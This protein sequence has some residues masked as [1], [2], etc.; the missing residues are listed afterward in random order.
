[1]HVDGGRFSYVADHHAR[2]PTYILFIWAIMTD[3]IKNELTSVVSSAGSIVS[4]NGE[5]KIDVY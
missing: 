1:M 3:G 4:E 2:M 5:K